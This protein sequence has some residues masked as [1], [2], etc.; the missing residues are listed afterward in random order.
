MLDAEKNGIEIV[1]DDLN[2]EFEDIELINGHDFSYVGSQRWQDYINWMES[3]SDNVKNTP[4]N[5][6]GIPGTHDSGTYDLFTD[7]IYNV[8]DFTGIAPTIAGPIIRALAVTQEANIYAQLMEGN[9]YIDLRFARDNEGRIRIVHTVFGNDAQEIFNQIRRFLSEHPKEVVIIDVQNINNLTLE[10]QFKLRD[11]IIRTIGG[12]LAPRNTLTQ[13]STLNDFYAL[14]KNAALLYVNDDFVYHEEPMY[15]Y[16][17]LGVI[18]NPW[19]DTNDINY[20][21]QKNTEGIA[22][23]PALRSYLYVSQMVLTTNTSEVKNIILDLL[24]WLPIPIYGQIRFTQEFNNLVKTPG[25]YK[26]TEPHFGQIQNWI[27]SKTPTSSSSIFPNIV[28]L[29]F[30][31]KDNIGAVTA[32]NKIYG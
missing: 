20:L 13:T 23:L 25:I 32:Y 10:D 3:S 12:F 1:F 26:L 19:Y 29:D 22:T 9:R 17:N 4:L 5:K 14:G 15:W 27:V 24:K 7:E 8:N 2:F 30:Y 21:L 11:I 31:Q 16:R 6:L 28:M 18:R